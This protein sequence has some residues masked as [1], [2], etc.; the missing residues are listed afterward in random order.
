MT[1]P[2]EVVSFVVRFAFDR[3]S[4]GQ[5]EAQRLWHGVVRHVQSDAERHFAHWPDALDFLSHYVELSQ[6]T[7]DLPPAD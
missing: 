7:P 6:S 5:P 1:Q 3:P 4:D 2:A